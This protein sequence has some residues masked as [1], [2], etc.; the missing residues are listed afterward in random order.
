[1]SQTEVELATYSNPTVVPSMLQPAQD[2]FAWEDST[3]DMI[4]SPGNRRPH[5]DKC[6]SLT[7]APSRPV[8]MTK[9]PVKPTRWSHQALWARN[10]TRIGIV[11]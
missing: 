1:M 7:K 11:S 8:H 9:P 2:A 4:L 3:K 6:L 5:L 10:N